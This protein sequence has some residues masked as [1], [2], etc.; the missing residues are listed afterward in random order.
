MFLDLSYQRKL[1]FQ[2]KFVFECVTVHNVICGIGGSFVKSQKTTLVMSLGF[3]F[4]I[5]SVHYELEMW[6]MKDVAI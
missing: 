6:N 2:Y 5:E 4:L 1:H 3:N